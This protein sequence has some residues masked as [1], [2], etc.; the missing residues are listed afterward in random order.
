MRFL[1]KPIWDESCAKSTLAA[2]RGPE[3]MR[4]LLARVSAPTSAVLVR[5]NWRFTASI[6]NATSGGDPF[7]L[8]VC[9]V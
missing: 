7:T 4:E 6:A 2:L 8:S 9:E 1:K 3:S 5:C